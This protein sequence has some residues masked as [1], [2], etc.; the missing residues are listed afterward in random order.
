MKYIIGSG[1]WCAD[2]VQDTR[3]ELLGDDDIRGQKFHQLWYEAICRYTS[4]EKIIIV[5]SASPIK[6][7]LNKDDPRLEFVSLNVNAGHS[8]NHLGKFCGCV[9]AM[10]LGLE[11][12]LQCDADYYVY[13]EQD[14]LIYGEGI[15]E[16]CINQMV[17]PYMFGTGIGTPLRSQQSL[18]IIRKDGILP[19][20]QKL[21]KLKQTDNEICPEEKFHLVSSHGPV[22][23]LA[24]FSQHSKNNK[25]YAWLNWQCFKYLRN[26]Q[27]LPIGFGRV[28]PIDFDAP[29]FYFQHGCKEELNEYLELTGIEWSSND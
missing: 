26:W 28:K 3:T 25:L 23:L 15:I 21:N 6:P 2:K 29:Y 18:F 1:W 22:G 20:L 5:D 12:T 16:H 17:K 14:A 9:R 7:K 24:K 27:N 10:Q 4:P 11:Y 19:F 13:V 8:T